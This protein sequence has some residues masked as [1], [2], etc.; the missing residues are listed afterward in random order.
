MLPGF[1]VPVCECDTFCGGVESFP[2]HPSIAGLTNV[3]KHCVFGNGGHGV[4]VG[5]VWGA[6]S[7]TEKS[8]LWIDGPQFTYR[9]VTEATLNI[10]CMTHG[11]IEG[12]CVRELYPPF[13]PWLSNFIHAMSS[14]THSTFHP[15]R[16]GFIMAKL[17]LPQAL[18]KAA[19]T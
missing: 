7:H 12:V 10:C 2:P 5:L 19:A 3:G 1:A 14:P 9:D 18:G 13:S 4:G 6:W 8:V 17:V 15:G 16:A 11:S